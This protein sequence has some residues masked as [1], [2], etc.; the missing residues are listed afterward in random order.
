DAAN[1]TGIAST[2]FSL[3]VPIMA[4]APPAQ[5]WEDLVAKPVSDPQVVV[6]GGDGTATA[7]PNAG[8]GTGTA[9][10]NP[11]DHESFA[12]SPVPVGT[13]GTDPGATLAAQVSFQS[14]VND[15]S[16]T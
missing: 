9:T 1:T 3:A 5:G 4:V 7:D 16:T 12:L 10:G 11:V 13:I 14:T 2:A 15:Y 8:T 6:S